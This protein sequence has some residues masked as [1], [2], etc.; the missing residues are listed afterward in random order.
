[1][2]Q[3]P[4]RGVMAPMF[5]ALGIAAGYLDM[6]LD[7]PAL[8]WLAFL[9]VALGLVFARDTSRMLASTFKDEDA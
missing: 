4:L 9:A 2:R 1:M 5:S 7:R 8:G 6:R 3:L